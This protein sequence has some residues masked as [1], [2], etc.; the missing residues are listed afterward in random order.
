V[1]SDELPSHRAA[2][3]L[4]HWVAVGRYC[5]GAGRAALARQLGPHAATGAVWLIRPDQHVMAV[6]AIDETDAMERL[7]AVLQAA[8]DA[9]PIVCEEA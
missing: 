3:P 4:L 9:T 7:P 1:L 6:L 2:H 5:D 8:L